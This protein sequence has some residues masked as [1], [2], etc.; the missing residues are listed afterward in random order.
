MFHA[1][2][3]RQLPGV[4]GHRLVVGLQAGDKESASAWR[5]LFRLTPDILRR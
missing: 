1:K 3:Y 5:K 4:Q 2:G